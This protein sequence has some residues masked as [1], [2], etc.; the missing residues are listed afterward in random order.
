ME[1]ENI[2]EMDDNKTYRLVRMS[3]GKMVKSF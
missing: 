3:E 1:D 2:I